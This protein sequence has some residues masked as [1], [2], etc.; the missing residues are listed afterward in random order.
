[1]TLTVDRRPI[2]TFEGEKSREKATFVSRSITFARRRLTAIN[3]SIDR[4]F[5]LSRPLTVHFP[6]SSRLVSSRL[7]SLRCLCAVDKLNRSGGVDIVVPV[8][9][10]AAVHIALL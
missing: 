9:V 3:Q 6:L 1:M 2:A 10:R 4:R 8:C 5:D 7:T